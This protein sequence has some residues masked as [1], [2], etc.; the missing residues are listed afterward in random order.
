MTKTR[1][2]VAEARG[3]ILI[4]SAP[5]GSGKSTIVRHLL[6]AAPAL[7]FS[8]SYTTR[9]PRQGEKNGTDYIFINSSRFRR[10]AAAGAFAESAR[11][12]GNYYGTPL[13]QLA[14]AQRQGRDI[15][16][17]IDVQGHRKVRRRIPGAVS[18]FLMPPSLQELDRRLC[19]RRSDG[20]EDIDRRLAAAREE[21][22]HGEEYDYVVVNDDVRRATRALISIL[23]AARLRRENQRERIDKVLKTF[24]G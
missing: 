22:Q 1:R 20:Q 5:S 21:V 14:A 18:V 6:G 13:R 9:P 12:H 17:D 11:V 16:L 15:L 8:V 7:A 4:I 3:S 10:M 23:S 19:Q 24:G 2:C